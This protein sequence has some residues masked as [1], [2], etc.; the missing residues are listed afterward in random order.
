ML[1]CIGCG[2]KLTAFDLKHR[3]VGEHSDNTKCLK[4]KD[5]ILKE[6]ANEGDKVS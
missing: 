3:E 4:C 5:R 1:K 2:K 6:R